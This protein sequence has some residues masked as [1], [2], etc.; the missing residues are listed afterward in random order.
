MKLPLTFV[1]L[2]IASLCFAQRQNVYFLKNNGKHVEVRDSADYIRIVREPDSGSVYFNVLE[3]YPN[4]IHKMIGKTSMIDPLSL[5]GACITYFKNGKKESLINYK[6][7]RK[8]G[9]SY[10]YFPNGKL[11]M[12]KEFPDD[13]N[14][15]NDFDG[16]YLLTDSKD[17][18]GVTL[19][20]DGNGHYIGYDDGFK[21]ITEEGE[22][23]NGKREGLWKGRH[24]DI[25]TRFEENYSNGQLISGTATLDN[26]TVKNY[27]KTRAM[28]PQ[29]KGGIE[30]F[31]RYLSNHIEYPISARQNN[32]QGRVVL[33]FV[34]EK[35]GQVTEIKVTNSVSPDIDA[36]AV[37]VLKA[38][39]KWIPGT[40][41]GSLVRV[42]YSVP[43]SFALN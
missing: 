23:K 43:V 34:V 40:R 4:G 42:Q 22:I 26:G 21:K 14:P 6:K 29:F 32:I 36:E 39:P 25:H 8:V 33:T 19:I 1:L 15:Y 3:F 16:N 31:S 37:R 12:A 18:L 17:S 35:D 5:E 10:E 11:Y 24:D 2:F 9:S 30:G 7:G 13:E 38:S 20:S 27:T 41:F 28:P